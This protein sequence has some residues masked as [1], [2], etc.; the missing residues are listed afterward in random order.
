MHQLSSD[1]GKSA[2]ALL[3]LLDGKSAALIDVVP[4]ALYSPIRSDIAGSKQ[5]V[6]RRIKIYDHL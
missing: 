1:G 6:S 5:N 2:I 4:S 3:R